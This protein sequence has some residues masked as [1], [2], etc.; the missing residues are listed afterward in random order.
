MKKTK[1]NVSHGVASR[2][3]GWLEKKT[4]QEMALSVALQSEKTAAP[5]TDQNLLQSI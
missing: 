1:K 2:L 4:K 3:L 5:S